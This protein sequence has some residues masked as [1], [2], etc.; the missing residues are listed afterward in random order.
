MRN[1][2]ARDVYTAGVAGFRWTP[3]RVLHTTS[4]YTRLTFS[5]G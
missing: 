4:G 2:I 5:K 3:G 1:L